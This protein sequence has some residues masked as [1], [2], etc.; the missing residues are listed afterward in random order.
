[1]AQKNVLINFEPL[2]RIFSWNTENNEVAISFDS[3][4]SYDSARTPK[5]V[6]FSLK[7]KESFNALGFS[8]NT[9]E[10][11][12]KNG[13]TTCTTKITIS[14]QNSTVTSDTDESSE[15]IEYLLGSMDLVLP[16]VG[17]K[18]N[19]H[20]YI[21][22]SVIQE[23]VRDSI[24]D[25]YSFALD[26]YLN[27]RTIQPT[28]VAVTPSQELQYQSQTMSISKHTKASTG[29]KWYQWAGIVLGTL[30]I[31]WIIASAIGAASSK[32]SAID[33]AVLN[34]MQQDPSAVDSQVKLTRETL[35]EMGLD[36]SGNNADLGCLAQ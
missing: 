33:N 31:L 15:K 13:V 29:F 35:K 9:T 25:E 1:M 30:F 18:N 21:E 26:Q 6:I 12:H 4:F 17:S 14:Q 28:A 36:V 19:Q 2:V 5:M 22:E 23:A 34:A 11:E 27:N 7:T 16:A 32:N 24:L 10:F 20:I 3:N 8:V